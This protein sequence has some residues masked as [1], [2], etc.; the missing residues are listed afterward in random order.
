[1]PPCERSQDEDEHG[2]LRQ[3][4]TYCSSSVCVNSNCSLEGKTG[5]Q[6]RTPGPGQSRHSR[7]K[8]RTVIT[9]HQPT[10]PEGAVWLFSFLTSTSNAQAVSRPFAIDVGHP[11]RYGPVRTFRSGLSVHTGA[12][13]WISFRP[14]SYQHYKQQYKNTPRQQTRRTKLFEELEGTAFMA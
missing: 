10:E 3:E 1:M 13:C 5:Q 2:R 7:T 8:S 4:E 12:I 6:D 14:Y 9:S 11:V